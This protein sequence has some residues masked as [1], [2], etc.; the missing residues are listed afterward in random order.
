VNG[1]F[2]G[3]E[4]LSSAGAGVNITLAQRVRL[5]FEAAKPLTRTPYDRTDRDW[6]YFFSLMAQI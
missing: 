3:S 4:S 6:R 2:T 5:K 1:A